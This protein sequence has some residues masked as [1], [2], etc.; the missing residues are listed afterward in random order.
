MLI[1]SP[2]PWYGAK[3]SM[4]RK[5]VEAMPLHKKYISAF[6]GSAG[7]FYPKPKADEEILNDMNPWACVGHRAVRDCPEEL[8]SCLPPIIEKSVWKRC[9]SWVRENKMGLP[10]PVL[11]STM[12]VAYWGAFNSSPWS[13]CQ[14]KRMSEQ[15]ARAFRSGKVAER[16]REGH[17]R[18]QGVQISRVDAVS[19][20]EKEENPDCLIFCDPPYMRSGGG[21]RGAAYGGYGPYE[22][23]NIRWHRRLLDAIEKAISKGVKIMITTGKDLLYE[24]RL[25]EIGLELLGTSGTHGAGK[26]KGGTATAEHL[27]WRSA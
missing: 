20:I 11:A 9:S 2:L 3:V 24:T 4:S 21:S 25:R 26:G 16:I 14:S 5:I 8:I 23:P 18:L 27:L 6:A 12:I 10:D 17:Q 15:Y 7:E 22:P 13:L 1:R 19:L